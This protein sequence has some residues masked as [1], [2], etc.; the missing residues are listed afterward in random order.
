MAEPGANQKGAAK[1][2][3]VRAHGGELIYETLIH[4]EQAYLAG[5][6]EPDDEISEEGSGVWRRAREMPQLANLKRMERSLAGAYVPG[7]VAT[8]VVALA[9]LGFLLAGHWIVAL[10]LA[11]IL[12][13]LLF[14]LTYKASQ[15]KRAP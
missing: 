9:S 6:V 14:R 1:R 4:V 3:L 7:V 5:L 11:F 13:A 10:V 15:L 12:S 2:Y 8:V